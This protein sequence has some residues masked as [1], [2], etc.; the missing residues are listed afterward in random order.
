MGPPRLKPQRVFAD[1]RTW[2]PPAM[3]DTDLRMETAEE[4]RWADPDSLL[5]LLQR[6]RGEGYRRSLIEREYASELV[7]GCIIDDPRLDPQIE[8]RGWFYAALVAEL[9][10]DLNLLRAAYAK[11]ETRNPNPFGWDTS[12]WLA[13]RRVRARRH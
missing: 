7:V 5:G 12:A 11:D 4:N 3:V 6:G 8:D 13:H 9:G 2:A 1:Q 10:I